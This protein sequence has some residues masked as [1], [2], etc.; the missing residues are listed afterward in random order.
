MRFT[1]TALT[2][3]AA[4]SALA[5]PAPELDIVDTGSGAKL[6]ERQSSCATVR[7]PRSDKDCNLLT[8]ANPNLGRECTLSLLV[9]Q[10]SD[11]LTCARRVG[12][13]S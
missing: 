5:M 7:T 6:V 9:L 2:I 13:P 4:T 10:V 11:K 3:L 1:T 8:H 12:P